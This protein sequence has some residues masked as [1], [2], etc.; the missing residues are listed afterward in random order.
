MWECQS[1]HVP[2]KSKRMVL[3]GMCGVVVG[4]FC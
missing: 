3:M 4:L 1:R 2:I